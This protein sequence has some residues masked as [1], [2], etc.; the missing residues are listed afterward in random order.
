MSPSIPAASPAAGP[1]DPA[2][3]P[4][5]APD[6]APRDRAA[7]DGDRA[8]EHVAAETGDAA[9]SDARDRPGAAWDRM[10]ERELRAATAR[11][12]LTLPD[13]ACG[14]QPCR[15]LVRPPRD[16]VG[17]ALSGGGN[18]SATFNLGLLQGLADLDLLPAF[19]YLATVS[20]GGYVGGFWSA[21]LSR[22]ERT[23]AERR[24]GFPGVRDGDVRAEAPE[25]RHLRQFSNFLSPRVGLLSWDTGRMVAAAVSGLV[26]AFAAALAL[27]ALALSVWTAIAWALAV[28]AP[29]ARHDGAL[30]AGVALAAPLG[31]LL[32]AL[33]WVWLRSKPDAPA[34]AAYRLS[35]AG[36]VLVAGGAWALALRARV[37]AYGGYELRLGAEPPPPLVGRAIALDAALVLAPVAA[38]AVAAAVLAMLRMLLSR[39]RA[40]TPG[41]RGSQSATERVIARV[42]FAGAV[43]AVG[44][45]VWI[46][47]AALAGTGAIGH[48]GAPAGA[49]GVLAVLTALFARVQRFVAYLPRGSADGSRARRLAP[50]APQ[51]L[52]YVILGGVAVLVATGL[53]A[54]HRAPPVA[55]VLPAVCAA[56]GAAVLV[57]LL[58]AV[59]FD[60]N[61][62]G[63]HAFYRAR[64]ARAYLGASNHA[65]GQAYEDAHRDD[66]DLA[67]LDAPAA[68]GAAAPTPGARRAATP[69]DDG[70]LPDDAGGRQSEEQPGDDLPL[71][72]L[73][74]Q[75]PVHL[76]CC[77]ANDLA[78]RDPVAN[79]RRGAR[80]AVLSAYG[81][82]V[83]DAAAEWADGPP[84]PTDPAA[85]AGGPL[86]PES[87][88]AAMTASAAAFNSQMG[89]KSVQLGPAVTFL[90]TALNLRLG[91]WLP[92][93]T[94]GCAAARSAASPASASIASC[95]GRRAPRRR[96]CT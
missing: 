13:D 78:P 67:A 83:G 5:T 62:V 85:D 58:T 9:G 22:R 87:L 46:A 12:R 35:A 29:G 57:T 21:W 90:M 88:G 49:A 17:L 95:S 16:L 6:R 36:A 63:L 43:W 81:F 60:P 91:R 53:V 80:S 30:L 34:R 56:Y 44:G 24:G 59:C 42:L 93:P 25:V 92:H 94:R 10:V 82:G 28:T 70:R 66:H 65:A 45:G 72:A 73:A 50:L 71:P 47:G 23:P 68:P 3:P 7:A 52:A 51:V 86:P 11:P 75:R 48:A 33:E 1:P 20:G 32:V 37:G 40:A 19:D 18:R 2:A 77:A 41:L 79:L 38:C 76:V 64:L 8:V 74:G 14:R 84:V 69:A 61:T 15:M 27:V 26:P 96:A 89:L 4:P 39:R 31:V 54:L 55:G